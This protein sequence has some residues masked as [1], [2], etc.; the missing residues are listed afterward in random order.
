MLGLLVLLLL[1]AVL[2]ELDANFL[3]CHGTINGT[4]D[5]DVLHA[6]GG[7]C[8][9]NAQVTGEVVAMNGGIVELGP[10]TIIGDTVR[11]NTS[12]SVQ[13]R[14]PVTI[15]GRD[16][17]SIS[18][19]GRAD[20]GA[21]LSVL[22]MDFKNIAG[23]SLRGVTV[24][25]GGVK[26][27]GID[28][29]LELCGNNIGDVVEF[30][31]IGGDFLAEEGPHCRPNTFVKDVKID[32]VDGSVRINGGSASRGELVLKNVGGAVFLENVRLK[33]VK[34]DKCQAVLMTAVIAEDVE[35]K[36]N[37]G[38]V[39]VLGSTLEKIGCFGNEPDVSGTDNLISDGKGQCSQEALQ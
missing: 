4:I 27:E 24:T 36:E 19:G 10:G 8:T 12:A 31:S 11:A 18:G 15:L 21:G 38:G 34:V 3:M 23:A 5:G 7:L 22:R 13:T 9:V 25:A 33:K 1:A 20:L 29:D 30:K 32:H 26:G 35:L 17:L 39:T 37:A 28:G 6:Q 2:P 16:G 14:G